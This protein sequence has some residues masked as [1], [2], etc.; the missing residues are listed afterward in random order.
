M[1]MSKSLLAPVAVHGLYLPSVSRRPGHFERWL[2]RLLAARERRAR[3]AVLRHLEG[4]IAAASENDRA[5]HEA[6]AKD[7]RRSLG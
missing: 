7:V 5:R 4:R 2:A 1:I 3:T 6:A